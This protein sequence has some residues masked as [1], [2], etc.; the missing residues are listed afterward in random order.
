MPNT[1][2]VIPWKMRAVMVFSYLGPIFLFVAPW[3]G[4]PPRSHNA[5]MVEIL[6]GVFMV[7]WLTLLHYFWYD[8]QKQ[9]H[10]FIQ[11]LRERAAGVASR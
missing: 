5:R 8:T 1:K 6:C 2:Y 7:A 3:V 11:D 9:M 10:D 4:F